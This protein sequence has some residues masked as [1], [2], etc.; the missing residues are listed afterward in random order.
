M[1]GL[2]AIRGEIV[3]FLGDP[4]DLGADALAHFPDGLLIVRDGLVAEL[5]P[6]ADLLPRLPA[7]TTVDD[8]RG[9]LVL[10][11]FIDTHIHYAQTDIVASY[12]E[13]VL[14]WL[15]KYTY[16]TE[17]RFADPAHAAAVAEFFCDE[18]LRNGTTT[19]MA[20]A[21]VHPASVDALFA[22]A[23]KRHMRMI[24][25]KVLMDRNCPDFLRD[26]ADG[27][28]A[29][30]K[31][32]IERWHGR[33]RL[34]YAVTPRFAPTSTP[35]QMALAGRLFA[36]HPGVYLQSH[37]AENERE[38]AW[39]ARLYPEAR[40]YLD[41]YER[42]GQLGARSVFAHCVWIDD[43][44]RTRLAA[45]GAAIS[46]CPTSNLFLGSGLFD[47]DRAHAAGVR[48]GLG[49]DV[50]GGTSFSMLQTLN[51]AYKVQQLRGQ[52]LP[53]ERGFYLATRGGARSLYLDDRIGSFDTGREA[54]LVV[55]DPAATP[56][57][58]RRTA[59][60]TTLAERLFAL[61]LLGDDRA[62]A[63]TWVMGEPAW[64][65]P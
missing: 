42:Y 32:L 44:D 15:E 45:T 59:V 35:A 28:D 13:Q 52:R 33:D 20:F 3:H 30:S 23:R 11:G 58:A 54:D 12:G 62:V 36:D 43:T 1:S 53:V 50:G 26:P 18:L 4:A 14:A 25:G 2:R 56:L 27:G 41:V 17:R 61:M 65:R 57:L 24:A 34:L 21:T 47:L 5:G 31:A 40:S 49:T 22:A 6:A 63:A 48:V 51:E 8:Y 38:V 29:E 10:P 55:L 9:K 39:V 60:A 7:G 46:F 64:R 19:A 37:L 16:P